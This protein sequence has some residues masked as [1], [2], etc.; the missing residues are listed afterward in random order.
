MATLDAI[1]RDRSGS[2]PAIAAYCSCLGTAL[3]IAGIF[4]CTP[5]RAVGVK[6][7]ENLNASHTSF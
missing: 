4:V 1:A 2:R 7:R 3:V 5:Q 6:L